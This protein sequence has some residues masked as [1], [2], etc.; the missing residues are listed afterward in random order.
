MNDTEKLKHLLEHWAEHNAEHAQTYLEWSKK[1]DSLGKQEL[2]KVLGEL[3][4]NTLKLD[5]LFKKALGLF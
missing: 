5:G 4:E 1:A 2:S 3:S